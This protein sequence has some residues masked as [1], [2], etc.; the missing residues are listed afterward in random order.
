MQWVFCHWKGIAGAHLDRASWDRQNRRQ[1]SLTG[2]EMSILK[3][4]SAVTNACHLSFLSGGSTSGISSS[5]LSSFFCVQAIGHTS[6]CVSTTFWPVFLNDH[7]GWGSP[8]LFF[9][10]RAVFL[11]EILHVASYVCHEVVSVFEENSRKFAEIH[12]WRLQWTRR[13]ARSRKDWRAACKW[14]ETIE[15]SYTYGMQRVFIPEL[16]LQQEHERIRLVLSTNQA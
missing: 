8:R 11:P 12:S 13:W 2:N 16:M 6:V 15:G 7:E 14:L 4:N 9:S 1:R 3:S 5:S 10:G